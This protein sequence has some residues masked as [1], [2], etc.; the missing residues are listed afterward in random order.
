VLFASVLPMPAQ[1]GEVRN[2]AAIAPAYNSAEI[3]S[4]PDQVAPPEDA[5]NISR[6]SRISSRRTK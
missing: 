6:V 5:L 1:T 2:S 3:S 4:L